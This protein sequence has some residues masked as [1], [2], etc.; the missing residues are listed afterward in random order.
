MNT[1]NTMKK[2][3]FLMLAGLL[4][5]GLGDCERRKTLTENEL[6]EV[7]RQFIAE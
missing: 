1:M 5:S 3:L 6:P 4:L 7:S 2:I